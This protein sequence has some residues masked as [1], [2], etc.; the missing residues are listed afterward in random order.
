MNYTRGVSYLIWSRKII[1]SNNKRRKI[2]TWIVVLVM[3]QAVVLT[4]PSLLV[5]APVDAA[6]GEGVAMIAGGGNFSLLLKEDGTVWAWGNNAEGQ[7]G[8]GTYTN[9]TV[10]TPVQG[11]EGKTITAIAAG[12]DFAVALD[13][14]G[15]VWVWGDNHYWQLGFSPAVMTSSAFPVEISALSTKTIVAIAAGSSYLVTLADDGT[16]WAWGNNDLGQLGLGYTLGE[17]GVAVESPKQV[18]LGTL[19]GRTVTAIVAGSSY[20]AVIA[21]DGTLWDCGNTFRL[22][23]DNTI[24]PELLGQVT[25]LEDF[26]IEEVAIG[27]AHMVARDSSGGVWSWG[28][29][30]KGQLGDGTTANQSLPVQVY[31]LTGVV[32]ISATNGAS[33][34]AALTNDGKVWTWGNNENGELGNG[35]LIN[36]SFP[37]QV[38]GLNDVVRITAG[39]AHTAVLK[40]DGTLWAW[41]SNSD[42]QLGNSTITDSNVPVR[43]AGLAT[44]ST[45][46]AL[47][48][49]GLNGV[50]LTVHVS[51]DSFV[52]SLGSDQFTLNNAPD[53]LAVTDAVYSGGDYVLTLSFD[54]DFDSDIDNLTVSIAAFALNGGQEITTGG[55]QI[56][57]IDEPYVTP[58]TPLTE[59]N[60]D[61]RTLT[62]ELQTG[63]FADD[64]LEIS[65]FTLN[66]A[67]PGLSLAS[68]QYTDNTT[69]TVTL[70]HETADFDSDFTHCSFTI[71]GSELTDGNPQTTD[72]L[73]ITA[74]QESAIV[75]ANQSLE[76]SSL[77]GSQLLV[78]LQNDTF[79]DGALDKANFI[80][81]NA[82]SGLS[83]SS[84]FYTGS[85]R[86]VVTLSYDGTYFSQDI[87][88]FSLTIKAAE[89]S[90][91]GDVSG[92]NLTITAQPVAL[93]INTT[94]LPD[95]IA[96]T[97]YSAA[98]QAA[99]GRGTYIWSAS[100]L[101]EG[102]DIDEATGEV[103]GTTDA[104]G[105]YPVTFTVEDGSGDT[106]DKI[107]TLLV[108]QTADSGKY[109]ITPVSDSGYTIGTEEGIA[110]MTVNGGAGG[111]MYFTVTVT[112]VEAHD[113]DEVVVFVQLR[114]STQLNINATSADFDSVNRAKAGFNVQAGDMIKVYIVDDL[115]NDPN[116][117]PTLLQ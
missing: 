17:H 6:G 74:V 103:S 88:D 65:N 11:L 57:A 29:N 93:S 115:T 66:N 3:V 44:L 36:S 80:L 100:G 28:I 40:S 91:K 84:V 86:C 34:T 37:I 97:S 25:A 2:A 14:A 30:G 58:D 67:P 21:N 54:G 83:V 32:A 94:S 20:T 1:K 72:K 59:R 70:A 31:G 73:T 48:E 81:N 105:S 117:N 106:A 52:S 85:D 78:I 75:T 10:P 87:N 38:D 112:P 60:L 62:V 101:P 47:R 110:T 42:G 56:A 104:T 95:A 51:L 71:A 98:L 50:Q 27:V 90:S 55:L 107:L 35:T 76:R 33:H 108:K 99:G 89:M 63:T 111:F 79:R 49:D 53:G 16:V 15:K 64:T 43:V 69:C 24:A 114:N 4:T 12:Q 13:N 61:E 102:L 109:T 22:G 82:P 9:R 39:G 96:G 23:R 7:L 19:G 18:P 45:A 92:N 41:G 46:E 116:F 26:S 77:N 8:D 5:P 68:V 113:G